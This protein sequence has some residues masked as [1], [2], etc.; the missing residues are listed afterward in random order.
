M[1]YRF[2]LVICLLL[3]GL[4]SSVVALP[5]K[6]KPK[7]RLVV[8]T[9]SILD[10]NRLANIQPLAWQLA[11]AAKTKLRLDT[12]RTVPQLVE[13]LRAGEV[14]VAFLDPFGYL[15]LATD[16]RPKVEP[17]AVLQTSK[18]LP[19]FYSTYLIASKASGV[20]SLED[21]QQRFTSLS[22]VFSN[23]RSVTGNLVPRLFLSSLGLGHPEEQFKETTYATSHAEALQE[24][25]KGVTDI[26]A[27]G[28]GELEKRLETGDI[29]PEEVTVLWKS[30]EIPLGPVVCRSSL[31]E[32]TKRRLQKVLLRAQKRNPEA[33]AQF[34]KAWP[35]AWE[36]EG[37][38]EI[39]AGHY[40]SIAHIAPNREELRRVLELH[41]K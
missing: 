6:A 27:I 40:R 11:R 14:D 5:H 30:E 41:L 8:A 26:A 19:D 4:S 13:A 32:K 24:V 9:H 25:R 3:V 7:K 12:Y 22:M 34:K 10:N 28:A 20:E 15:L 39:P 16:P 35:G 31:P 33:L 38:V 23:P 36:A 2:L 37:F 21:L 29:K 17:L 1:R 18:E